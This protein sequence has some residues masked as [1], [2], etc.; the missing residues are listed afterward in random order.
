MSTKNIPFHACFTDKNK[1][2]QLKSV[3]FLSCDKNIVNLNLAFADCRKRDFESLLFR[4]HLRT[5]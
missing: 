3:Q 4:M 2:A 5:P 1:F